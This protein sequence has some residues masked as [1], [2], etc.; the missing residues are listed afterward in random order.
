MSK[1]E[2]NEILGPGCTGSAGGTAGKSQISYPKFKQ[3]YEFTR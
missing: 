3:G 2:W 1:T